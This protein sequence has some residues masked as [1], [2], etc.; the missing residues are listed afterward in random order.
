[1]ESKYVVNLEDIIEG[2]G[3]K[4]LDKEIINALKMLDFYTPTEQEN[5]FEQKIIKGLTRFE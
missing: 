2:T 1:M 5:I 4:D 3:D